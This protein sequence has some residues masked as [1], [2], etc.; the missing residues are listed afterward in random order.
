MK[1]AS[2][3][4][5]QESWDSVRKRLDRAW[6]AAIIALRASEKSEQ[7]ANHPSVEPKMVETQSRANVSVIIPALNE[8]RHIASVVSYAR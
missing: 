8:A 7:R 4:G 6:R 2:M 3:S 1:G 5:V